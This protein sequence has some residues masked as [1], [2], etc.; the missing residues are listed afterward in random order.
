MKTLYPVFKEAEIFEAEIIE[1]E[2]T[3]AL[4]T[5]VELIEFINYKPIL[6]NK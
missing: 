1:V 6:K 4:T 2:L 3:E 5:S